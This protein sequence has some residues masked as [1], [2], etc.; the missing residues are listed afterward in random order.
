ME[1]TIPADMTV[2]QWRTARANAR[3]PFRRLQR[4]WGRAL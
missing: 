1:A 2:A 3:L 4:L